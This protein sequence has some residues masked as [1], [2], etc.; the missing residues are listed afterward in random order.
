MAKTSPKK[1]QIKHMDKYDKAIEKGAL[2]GA[3]KQQADVK[4]GKRPGGAKV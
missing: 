3:R 4:R 1:A 2:K